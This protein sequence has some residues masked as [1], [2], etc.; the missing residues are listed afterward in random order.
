MVNKFAPKI[1]IVAKSVKNFE[2]KKLAPKNTLLK[3]F[4]LCPPSRSSDIWGA[5][6]WRIVLI[7]KR[8]QI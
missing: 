4:K 8:N 3:H 7:W 1:N 2:P 6:K 5:A